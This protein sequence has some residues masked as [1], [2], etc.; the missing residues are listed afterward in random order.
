MAERPSHNSTMKGVTE[1]PEL[2]QFRLSGVG[3]RLGRGH[4]ALGVKSQKIE[5]KL[6]L[7]DGGHTPGRNATLIR[8]ATMGFVLERWETAS[9]GTPAGN[10]GL[11]R[12]LNAGRGT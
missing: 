7:P 3:G 4:A 12:P 10:G 1:Q 5:E 2:F 9:I 6:T 8:Q 11:G